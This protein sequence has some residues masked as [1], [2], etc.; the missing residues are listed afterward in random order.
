MIVGGIPSPF[1][2]LGLRSRDSFSLE[3]GAKAEGVDTGA[4]G[5]GVKMRKLTSDHFIH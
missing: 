5:F 4:G 3:M 2:G 1:V